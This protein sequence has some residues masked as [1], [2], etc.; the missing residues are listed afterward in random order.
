MKMKHGDKNQTDEFA[1]GDHI[2]RIHVVLLKIYRCAKMGKEHQ[3]LL[4]WE[5]RK[6]NEEHDVHISAYMTY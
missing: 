1:V 2:M 6:Q 4:L 3:S 5:Y